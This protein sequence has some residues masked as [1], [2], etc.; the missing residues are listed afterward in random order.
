VS[1]FAYDDDQCPR[2]PDGLTHVQDGSMECKECGITCYSA[3][4][5]PWREAPANSDWPVVD[6]KEV[7]TEGAKPPS[8]N[9]G[10]WFVTC[11]TMVTIRAWLKIQQTLTTGASAMDDEAEETW[12][13]FEH[14]RQVKDAL[15]RPSVT[16]RR[17]VEGWIW[18]D[19]IDHI[20]FAS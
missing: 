16:V 13:C 6:R 9:S 4:T 17:S 10:C 5:R 11:D 12:L 18:V 14:E 15:K 19:N 7:E 20:R 3:A 2:R 8:K 1:R